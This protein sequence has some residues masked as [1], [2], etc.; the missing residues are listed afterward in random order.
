MKVE[1]RNL[2]KAFGANRVLDQV[3]FEGEFGHVWALIGPSG[4]GKSTLLRLLAGLD[5]PDSGE[6]LVEGVAL[7]RSEEAL[8]AYRRTVG[9]T[10]SI[11]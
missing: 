1:L 6:V 9:R 5:R 2:S 3:T 4:G 11:A 7:A 10:H 8:R